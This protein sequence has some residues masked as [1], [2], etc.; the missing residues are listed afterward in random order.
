MSNPV[1][2][3][4]LG[5]LGIPL[6][7]VGHQ[8]QRWATGRNAVLEL[9]IKRAEDSAARAKRNRHLRAV[10]SD[11]DVAALLLHI[12]SAPGSW[13]AAEDLR[14]TLSFLRQAGKCVYATLESASNGAIYIASVADRVFLVPTGEVNLVGV[15]AELTFFG[16]ALETLG[17]QPDLEA[18]GAY[19]SF[20]EP[21]MR[22][23]ASKHNQEALDLLVRDL[24]EQ[25][26]AGLAKA[27]TLDVEAV[28]D[29]I[30]RAPL[31]AVAAH[32]GGLVDQLAYMDEVRDWVEEQHGKKSKRIEFGVYAR[33]RAA[34]EAIDRMGSSRPIVQVLHLD[35]PI[36]MEQP[37]ASANIRARH[38]VEMLRAIR[39]DDDIKAVVLHVNS[40][41]GNALASDLMWREVDEM[42]K[43]KAVVACFEDVAASGG[44]YLAA[45]ARE[46][47]A[48]P[49]TLTGSIGVFGGKLVMG[50]GMR[51]LGVNTQA[52]VSAPNAN[53]FTP[54]RPFTDQQRDRFRG[55]LQRFYDGFVDRVAQGRRTAPALIEPHCRG[56][57]WT[58]R[59][60]R[61]RGLVDSEGDLFKAVERAGELAELR[62]GRWRRRD[63][64]AQP[65]RNMLQQMVQ[66]A[67]REAIPG[68]VARS[69]AMQVVD[70]TLG[71][72]ITPGLQM[73]FDNEG[74]MLAM[75]PFEL[76]DLS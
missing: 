14:N 31:S 39:E 54:S 42:A 12:E 63:A 59:L 71:R 67:V 30:A 8:L 15:G 44:F 19:K 70:K 68:A 18:A 73:L 75:L 23:F 33:R 1:S 32:E 56:R 2:Q 64:T 17:V 35:G 58:G 69:P 11:P 49:N 61:E 29:L 72:L 62:P 21:Y 66:Q 41:G 16:R 5:L 27:R 9:R 3:A 20:G 57:V 36:V 28:E 40:P 26:V 43:E 47:I 48:R 37:G 13:A 22:S 55:S 74:Q 4:V 10:A 45:P 34:L 53:L 38:V 25:L 76:D 46:I 50:E 52:I 65:A 51:K 7:L 60:A 24:H 6:G